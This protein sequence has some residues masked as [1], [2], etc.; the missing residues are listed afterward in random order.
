MALVMS[1]QLSYSLLTRD[2][3]KHMTAS[4]TAVQLLKNSL[5]RS[6][7]MMQLLQYLGYGEFGSE[8]I[9]R[10]TGIM[11]T[12]SKTSSTHISLMAKASP[13]SMVRHRDFLIS[14]F[15]LLQL[16]FKENVVIGLPKQKC[17]HGRLC[18]DT[19]KHYWRNTVLLGD[20]LVQSGCQEARLNCKRLSQM[21]GI[22]GVSGKL[23]SSNVDEDTTSRL[24]LQLQQNTL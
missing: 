1:V 24:W 22:R 4:I 9:L 5:Y 18:V 6:F 20:K 12:T 15:D 21:A 19:R 3:T 2:A 14:T 13:S 10:A 16:A 17:E 7:G 8:R 23:C 11:F